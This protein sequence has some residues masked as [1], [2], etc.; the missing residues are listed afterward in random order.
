MQSERFIDTL[1]LIVW[2]QGLTYG[3]LAERL[4]VSESTL[5]R[6][7]STRRASLERVESI[8]EALGVTFFDVA[9]R[10]STDIEH[11]V[12]RLTLPQE[13]RLV[14]DVELFYFFW[15][16]VHRHSLSSISRRYRVSDRKLQRWL[17]ELDR[18]KIIELRTERRYRLLIPSNVVWNE[19]GPIER[20]M[21]ARSLPL[22]LKGRFRRDNEFHRFIVGK[23]TP[24][25]MMIFR[26]RLVELADQLFR[27][28]VT[29]DALG[30]D[31]KTAACHIAFGPAS[32]SLRDV[33][34]G[35]KGKKG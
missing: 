6:M 23:L 9:R 7:F 4:D 5:K 13:R 19:D 29:V 25:S 28:S 34:A 16:L 18:L 22:F 27:Q 35:G 17:V 2:E 21:V 26:A 24:E 10:A 30:P 33:V 3:E 14:A 11:E 12:Y 1:K 31:A 8:C 32:F 15:M 20:L